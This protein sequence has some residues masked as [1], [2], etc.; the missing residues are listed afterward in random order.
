VTTQRLWGADEAGRGPIIGPMAIA[1]V[2]VDRRATRALN[3]LA[4]ADSKSYGHG[5]EAIAK[6]RELALRIAEIVPCYRI[7]VVDVAEIDRYTYRGQLNA[8]ER[9][10]V[11]QLLRDAG[12]ERDAKVICDGERLFSPLRQ[13]FPRLRAVNDGESAHVSVAAAS[14]LAK[15]ARD[16][17]FAVIA[18]RYEAQF[19]PIRGGGYINAGTKRF[20]AAYREVHG[21]LPPEARRSWG[22]DKIDGNLELFEL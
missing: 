14:I 15:D 13:Q 18:S 7:R 2:G 22:A 3:R 4:V 11:S 9:L 16:A 21:D 17:A 8:L 19:G 5:E 12:A 6:R 10:V 1:I 20:L